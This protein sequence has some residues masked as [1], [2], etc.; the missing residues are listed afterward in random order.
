MPMMPHAKEAESSV[1]DT[2]LLRRYSEEGAEDAFRA[3]VR[4]HI[5][6]VYGVALRKV[7]GDA[8]LA[9][10]V[11]Q[12]VFTDLARKADALR[13]HPALAGWLFTSSHYTAAHSCAAS[14]G[15]ASENERHNS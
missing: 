14:A 15:V 7:G 13:D 5:D 3:L 10:D 6:M 11:A 9:G 8:H 1:D 4:R 12:R 2:T